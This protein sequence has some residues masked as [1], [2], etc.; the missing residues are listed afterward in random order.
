MHKINYKIKTLFVIF[1]TLSF[2]ILG[3][4]INK[5]TEPN[6]Y[7]M[8]KVPLDSRFQP[9]I[10]SIHRQYSKYEVIRSNQRPIY[11]FILQEVEN[12]NI[13]NLLNKFPQITSFSMTNNHVAVL[14]KDPAFVDENIEEIINII[15]SDLKISLKRFLIFYSDL[16]KKKVNTEYVEQLHMEEIEILVNE[17][18][19]LKSDT[20]KKFLKEQKFENDVEKNLEGSLYKQMSDLFFLDNFGKN[21]IQQI[22]K[23]IKKQ[24]NYYDKLRDLET[25]AFLESELDNLDLLVLSGLEDRFNKTPSLAISIISF[26]SVGLFIGLIFILLFSTT[27]QK[28]LKQRSSALLNLIQTKK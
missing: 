23:I 13:S 16:M 15:N 1:I 9:I 12:Y 19:D 20:L 6:W 28:I 25:L 27:F 4:Y 24:I 8:Y 22:Q 3:I 17:I 11:E 14:A 26:G 21:F 2:S 5:H 18:A 7:S 10:N